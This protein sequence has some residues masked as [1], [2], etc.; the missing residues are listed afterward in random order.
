MSKELDTRRQSDFE[1]ALL[2]ANVVLNK[3]YLPDLGDGTVVEP[4]GNMACDEDKFNR[5]VRFFEVDKIILNRSENARDKLVSVF[6]AIWNIDSS[7]LLLI[8]G[9]KDAVS[10]KVG[11]RTADS[12]QIGMSQ[13]VVTKAISGNFPGTALHAIKKDGVKDVYNFP[14][15]SFVSAVT[16]IP[17]VRSREESR[18]RQY[19]QGLEKV[20]DSLQGQEYTLLLIADPVSNLDLAASRSALE[21]LYSSLVP[22]SESQYTV[23]KNTTDTLSRA[24]TAGT[25]RTISHSVSQTVSRTVGKSTSVSEGESRSSTL[26]ISAGVG[27]GPVSLG[28]FWAIT[29]GKSH[30][31]TSGFNSSDTKGESATDGIADAT[32]RSETETF[33]AAVGQSEGVQIKFENHA[34]KQMMLKIDETLKRYDTCAD[35]GMWNCAMYC[36]A[37]SKETASMAASVYQS[38]MR[39]EQSSLEAS[40]I[41]CWNQSQSERILRCLRTMQH[42]RFN[43]NGMEVTPGTLVSSAELAIQ[44]GLPNRSVPGIPVLECAEFGRNVSSFD[45]QRQGRAVRLGRIFHMHHQED[46]PVALNL[47]S[48]ASHTFVTGSTGSGKS[49]TVYQLLEGQDKQDKQHGLGRQEVN[50]LVVE[51]A[52]GEYKEVLGVSV[53]GTNPGLTPLLRINPFSFPH[54]NEEPSRNIHILEHLDRLVEIFNVCWPMYAAMPAVLKEAVEKSYE[55]C[56]WNLAE[57]ANPYGDGLYPTFADVTR[58]IRTIIDSSE[59]DAENKGAY[60]GALVTRLKSLTN[61]INGLIFTTDELPATELFDRKVIVDLSRVGSAETKSLIMGLLVLKLQEHRMTEGCINSPL[62]HVTV[63]EEAHNLLKRTSTE[64]RQDSGNLLGKSVEMLANAIAEMR[65]YGEGFIIADQAPGLLDLSVIRNTNTKIVMRL[66]DQDD[67]ELVGRAANLNDDQI[68]EL[69]RLP[70][71]VAAV[72]QNNW[73]EP[74]LCRV[75]RFEGGQRFNHRRQDGE[76]KS[77][78]PE[79]RRRLEL[80]RL[81]C[82]GTRLGTMVEAK[83]RIQD[84]GLSSCAQVQAIRLL[85]NPSP[86]P[87]YTKLAPVMTELFP[88][89]RSVLAEAF[90]K[91]SDSGEWTEVVDR[92]IKSQAAGQDIDEE[93]LRSIRQCIITQLLHNEL[94]KTVLLERWSNEGGKR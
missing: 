62:R 93:L 16:T 71:G 22:F 3:S 1:A 44:A 14:T 57:S 32:N 94:G 53:Y 8:Q 6:N 70:V 90:E 5:H 66:P 7:F 74:V 61:G 55:D 89:A 75:E 91:T 68:A 46:L 87:R 34:I 56:G 60:K 54:G 82:E 59:Y 78:A 42:P 2:T 47:D 36:I 33:A 38:V 58:N 15:G 23:G 84:L 43:L 51:P 69:A 45:S 19:V 12:E 50:Y 11:V 92:E 83:E 80:A 39:G 30:T 52:K 41:T 49:N 20:I 81:L 9:G 31:E 13:E 76:E 48:L 37:T 35:L 63:L 73:I 86:S 29:K 65:T 4:F 67:R 88:Q 40:A 72:Y 21:S 17:G 28:S 10:V 27:I 64:Q 18:D 77:G 26:G 79:M 24:L 85:C 25:S